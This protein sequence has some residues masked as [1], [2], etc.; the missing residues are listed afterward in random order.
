MEIEPH[1]SAARRIIVIL[2]QN[3]LSNEWNEANVSAALKSLSLINNRVIVI[4]LNEF[5]NFTSFAKLTGRTG[6]TGVD[7]S[8]VCNKLK[9]LRWK[10][11]SENDIGGNKFWCQLRLAMPPRSSSNSNDNQSV[12]MVIQTKNVIPKAHSHGSLEVLV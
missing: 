12:A 8:S 2:S 5:A 4:I 11:N 10:I 1:A 3:S 6:V 9:V 7:T